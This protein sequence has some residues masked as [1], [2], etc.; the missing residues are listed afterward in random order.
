MAVFWSP[1]ETTDFHR[2]SHTGFGE[3]GTQYPVSEKTMN[4][5][6][7]VFIL[8]SFL[9]ISP[10]KTYVVGA[11]YS[12]DAPQS[13]TSNEYLTKYEPRHEISNNVV[14]AT[15]IA[16]DQPAHTRSLIRAFASHLSIL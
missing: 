11:H 12:L 10:K 1:K 9:L 2:G 14:C 16:S 4:F 7:E 8:F 6:K 3:S 5:I 15:S 13:D